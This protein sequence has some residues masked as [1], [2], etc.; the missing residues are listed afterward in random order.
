MEIQV[1][2]QQVIPLPPPASYRVTPSRVKE[3][4]A[5]KNL[6]SSTVLTPEIK[7]INI[8]TLNRRRET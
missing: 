8:H 3:I 6:I 7:K 4:L 1:V 5:P 2:N